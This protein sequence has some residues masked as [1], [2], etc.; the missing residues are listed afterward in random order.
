VS[1]ALLLLV[2]GELALR[3]VQSGFAR[4]ARATEE[5]RVAAETAQTT[6]ERAERTLE[7]VRSSLMERQVSEHEDE[8]DVF[9]ELGLDASRASIVR[10][11]QKA[12][13]DGFITESGVRS[14]VWWT[15]VHYRFVVNHGSPD[16]MVHLELDDTTVL[17]THPWED[18]MS[19]ED[20]YQGLVEAVRAAGRDLGVTLN[21]PTQSVADLSD[22]LVEVGRKRA[23]EPMGYRDL[24]IANHRTG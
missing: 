2:P 23:Q 10:A 18:G 9:R 8:L 11:L 13:S 1:V 20:F 14:P 22:M 6:A 7:E 17:S 19:S 24:S 4:A 16:L 21:D 3:W 15:D 5:V 12:T